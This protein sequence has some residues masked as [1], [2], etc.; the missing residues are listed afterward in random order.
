MSAL[1][2]E[3]SE[4]TVGASRAVSGLEE[5]GFKV[6]RKAAARVMNCMVGWFAN[7]LE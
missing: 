6:R 3:M 7:C 4:R 5:A 2:L 1:S